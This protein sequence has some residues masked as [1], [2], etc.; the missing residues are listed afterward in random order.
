MNRVVITFWATNDAQWNRA[1]GEISDAA[2]RLHAAGV[3]VSL[4]RAADAN[5]FA[6][7]SLITIHSNGDEKAGATIFPRSQ[8]ILANTYVEGLRV[9]AEINPQITALGYGTN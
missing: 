9:G 8:D 4:Y 2:D 7:D 5:Q 3:P 6:N 1:W